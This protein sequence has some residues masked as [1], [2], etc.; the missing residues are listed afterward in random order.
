MAREV[1][2]RDATAIVAAF[3]QATRELVD[4]VSLHRGGMVQIVEL[5]PAFGEAM[6]AMTE[7][8]RTIVEESKVL[9]TLGAN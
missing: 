4:C 2:M 1:V 6:A 5:V 3:E 8:I 7:Q 9:Y